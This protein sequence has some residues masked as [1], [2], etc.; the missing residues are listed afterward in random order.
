MSKKKTT[1]TAKKQCGEI[2]KNISVLLKRFKEEVITLL[3][4]NLMYN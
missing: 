1:T 3:N 2:F 4:I